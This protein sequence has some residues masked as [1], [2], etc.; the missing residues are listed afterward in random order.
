MDLKMTT[1]WQSVYDLRLPAGLSTMGP[2]AHRQ[3]ARWWMRGEANGKLAAFSDRVIAAKTHGLDGWTESPLGGLSLIL[4]LDQF[5]R[6][7]FAGTPD[8]YASDL[9]CVRIVDEGITHG[10]FN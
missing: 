9:D 7:L 8:A 2:E 1:E 10:H 3:V 5:A 4:L 6:G